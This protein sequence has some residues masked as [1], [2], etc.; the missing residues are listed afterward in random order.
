MY[1]DSEM[2]IW[3]ASGIWLRASCGRS[4]HLLAGAAGHRPARAVRWPWPNQRTD[5]CASATTGAPTCRASRPA[6]SRPRATASACSSSK[7]APTAPRRTNVFVSSTSAIARSVTTARAAT[8]RT[9]ATPLPGARQRP[10][11]ND[12]T[13]RTAR[14]RVATSRTYRRRPATARPMSAEAPA[15][16]TRTTV[17]LLR[18]P[19]PANLG[20]LA[21][22]LGLL[23]GGRQLHPARPRP[24]G[25]ES[26]RARNWNLLFALLA[27]FVYYNLLNLA[28]TWVSSG[29]TASLR[30]HA[31]PRQRAG[32]RPRSGGASTSHQLGPPGRRCRGAA[33]RT[34][35][36]RTVRRLIYA[37]SQVRG[38]SSPS[39]SW[40]LFFFIDFVDE[41]QASA[42]LSTL[43]YRRAQPLL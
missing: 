2:T 30:L 12:R 5:G 39:A 14:R 16:R 37:E 13:R 19:T 6:S 26:A 36:M 7:A 4:S 29:R 43:G 31:T 21:W 10:A 9:T 18:D 15:A 35:R 1:R 32:A 34:Q 33:T 8:S 27:F 28:Q 41:L 22:R 24:L 23:L 11:L 40:R 17:D 25:V 20:E 3:F 42:S 38:A